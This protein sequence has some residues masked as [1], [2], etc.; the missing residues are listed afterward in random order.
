MLEE[1]RTLLRLLWARDLYTGNWV[2]VASAGH[3]SALFL[4]RFLKLLRRDQQI[5]L[6]NFYLH[7]LGKR[8]FVRSILRFLLNQDVGIMAQSLDEVEYFRGTRRFNRHP[9]HPVLP[10]AS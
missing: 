8:R 6:Y 5:Y 4:G 10:R 9:L 3:Y 7:A 2:I 1:L